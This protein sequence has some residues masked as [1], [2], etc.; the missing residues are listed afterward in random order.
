MRKA[1]GPVLQFH[2]GWRLLLQR[3]GYLAS[4]VKYSLHP[5]EYPL[6]SLSPFNGGAL[7]ALRIARRLKLR[8][9]VQL[10]G[11]YFSTPLLPHY[12]SRAYDHMA[13]RGGLNIGAAGTPRKQHINSVFLGITRRC[14][15]HCQH[16]Y[17]HFNTGAE[18]VVPISRW[19]EVIRDIQASGAGVVILSGG[20]PMLRYE[21]ILELLEAGDKDL[22]DFHIHTSGQGVTLERARALRRAGLIAAAVGL[23]DV[24]PARHD[25]LRGSAGSH[26][27]AV[28]ALQDFHSSGVFTY[29]N[30]CLT[31]ELVRS[32]DLWK[33][34]EFVRDLRVGMIEMLEPRPCGGFASRGDEVLLTD[35]DR[36]KVWEFFLRGNTTRQ[37]RNYPLIYHVAYTESPEQVGCTMGGLTHL[38]I[39][40]KGNVN[41]CVFLPV[42]FGNI[43][44]EDFS[45]I[46]SRMRR[47][48][49]RPLHKECPSVFLA[50]T[51]LEKGEGRFPVPHARIEKE[52]EEMFA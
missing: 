51:L 20:E 5:K 38:A 41:P 33:Y 44:T 43:L 28:R 35:A 7:H 45:A 4:A 25:R 22:S 1:D 26:R 21:G 42:T 3:A 12:P 48:I 14:D 23:D 46:Y 24:D 34:F 52:W 15:L 36:E 9:I 49:P 30:M 10:N 32:G 37:F 16:C 19:K 18:E 13:A 50:A 29:T 2:S 39:D 6:F 31:R 40:S 27:Q 17:E 47:A 11:A 8:R